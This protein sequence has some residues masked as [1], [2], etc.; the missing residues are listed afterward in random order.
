[1]VWRVSA[2][3]EF[4][5]LRVRH[6]DCDAVNLRH[7]A[8]CVHEALNGEQWTGDLR[9]QRFDIPGAKRRI[10]PDVAPSQKRRIDVVVVARKLSSQ[11]SSQVVFARP[12]NAGDG[13]VFNKNMWCCDDDARYGVREQRRVYQRDGAA[14]AMTEQPRFVVCNVDADGGEKCRQYFTRLNVHEV[15][16]PLFVMRPRRRFAVTRTGIDQPARADCRAKL[17]RKVTPHRH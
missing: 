7:R 5:E 15:H 2:V 3:F 13:D 6:R 8:V 12:G 1:M 17:R 16:P 9:Q 14:V 4:D 11:I 10:Q